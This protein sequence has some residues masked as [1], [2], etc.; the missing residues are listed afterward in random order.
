MASPTVDIS[1]GAT[2]DFGTS[3][4]SAEVVDITPPGFS[5]EAIQTTHQE[6]ANSSHTFTPA[7]FSDKGELSFTIHF[8]PDTD[9][10]ID[11][12]AET[13]TLTFGSGADWAFSGFMTGYE[14]D[15]PFNDKMV[16]TVT[17]K[18]SGDVTVTPAA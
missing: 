12:V 5:R 18:V 6:T 13:I 15:A 14:P 4:F 17:V 1:S 7:D 9:P 2:I 11:A 3:S 8:N 16:A 10:P